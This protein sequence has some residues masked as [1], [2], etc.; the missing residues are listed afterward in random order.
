MSIEI[1]SPGVYTISIDIQPDYVVWVNPAPEYAIEVVEPTPYNINIAGTQGIPGAPGEKG[2]KG[3]PG[4]PGLNEITTS[5]ATNITGILKGNGTNVVA[6]VAGTDYGM[7][8]VTSVGITA[9]TGISVSGSPV[10]GSGSITV[11]NSA[12]DQTVTITAGTGINVTGSYPNFTIQNT[13]TSAQWGNITGTLSSQ[14]DL[15]NALNAKQDTLVSG[16]NIK[17]VNSNSLLGSGNVSVGT[18]TSVGLTMPSAFSVANSPVTGSGTLAVTGAGLADQYIRG[19]GSL[20]NFPTSVGGGSSVS[21]YLNGSVNQGTFGG[22]TYY[23]MNRTPIIGSG[24]NFT[25]GANGYIAQFITDAGDPALLSIPAGN[26]DFQ[27]HFS[28]S[29]AGGSPQFY[30]ELYKYDGTNFT[31]IVS[32]SASPQGITAGTAADVYSTTLAVPATSLTLTDRLAIRVYVLHS[33]RTITLYTED[34]KLA[35]IHTTFSTGLAALN[36]LTAQVQYLGVGTSGTDFN[37]ASATDTH[38]FN[39]PTAS[40]TNRGALSSADWSTFNNKQAALVSGTNIKTLE[41]QSLLGSGNIDLGKSDVGLGNVDNTSD[42][43]KPVSTATQAA[44]NKQTVGNNLY[45]FNNY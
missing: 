45:L 31:L 23:E 10:T 1:V 34:N 18:V 6:A 4:D 24:T 44:I 13:Q 41:G 42:L 17:T 37:I 22:N 9:G 8:T 29:S 40:A 15:Q 43:N 28:A 2:D 19:D 30:P 12:P 7:G 39:L 3:D 25:I 35:E 27:L 11:T 38:T 33:G 16:T 14:T 21:Y 20:A 26:W 32:G 5:T 36:G